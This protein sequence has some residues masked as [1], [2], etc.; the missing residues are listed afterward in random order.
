MN[1]QHHSYYQS[2][3]KPITQTNNPSQPSPRP[4]KP[5]PKKLF[6]KTITTNRALTIIPALAGYRRRSWR[7]V[8]TASATTG[9]PGCPSSRR[10]RSTRC[11]RA[12]VSG[13]TSATTWSAQTASTRSWGPRAR[14]PAAWPAR[15]ATTT[16]DGRTGPCRARDGPPRPSSAPCP[17]SARASTASEL[18][19]ETNVAL[20]LCTYE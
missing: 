11:Q 14:G 4:R 12:P 8:C 7:S 9:T 20:S 13:S 2:P 10:A 17:R 19:A 5:I 15:P 18:L 16:A 1:Y 6:T 3:R